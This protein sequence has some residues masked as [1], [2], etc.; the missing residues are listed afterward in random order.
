MNLVSGLNRPTSLL[1]SVLT[2]VATAFALP[3]PS[4]A[5]VKLPAVFGSHMVL[6]RDVPIPVW[7]WADPGEEVTVTLGDA[8]AKATADAA[9]AWKVMLP[10]LAVGHDPLTLQL[11]GKNTITLDDI[12]VGEVWLG[13]GQSNM[14]LGIAASGGNVR[15]TL[16]AANHPQL[17]LFH[18]P[19]MKA[20]EPAKD[21]KAEW[22]ICTPETVPAFSAALY[23]FGTRLQEELK[24]PVGLIAAA[25]SG[26]HIE[27]WTIHAGKSGDMYNGLI[28][29]LVPFPIRGVVWYQGE[30]S[31]L[32]KNGIA[33]LDK[34]KNLIGGWRQAWG[35]DSLPF[36][37][38]QIAPWDGR[39]EA[40]QL[41]QLWEAQ[42]AALAI[43][44]TGMVV[45]TDLVDNIKDLHPRNKRDV[46]HRL[47]RW[48]LAKTYGRGDVVYSGPLYKGKVV[49]GDTLRLSFAHAAG[50]ASRDGKPLKEF[51]IAGADGQFVP[52][53]ATIDGETV[54]VSA[55]G[56]AAPQEARFGWRNTAQPN[57]VNAAGLPASPFRTQEWRGA[58][59]E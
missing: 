39:Y 7:G 32:Q 43:P 51:E 49:D 12:L 33:Y 37:F 11:A 30:S 4:R 41:P 45:T 46:G 5:D 42:V 21:V 15:E 35:N 3:S 1:A 24:V 47:A 48:A 13:S 50:L 2:L 22:K 55:A 27:P 38:V 59:G 26:S 19:K 20:K 17:R 29:P 57:L 14:E 54:V 9:G 56:V 44:H 23:H 34:M 52:A 16:A 40:D 6:Q 36:Y 58:T 10:A 18:V 8:S 53:T 25:W 28:A 31:V